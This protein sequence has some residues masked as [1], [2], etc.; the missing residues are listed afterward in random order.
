M[1]RFVEAM[2]V[3]GV[4]AVPVAAQTQ[5]Q[6]SGARAAVGG[7]GALV[8]PEISIIGTREAAA[9]MPGSVSTIDARAMEQSR[10]VTVNEA[11]RSLPGIHVRDEEGFG[12]R[13]NIGLRGLNPTR[14][15]KVTLLED[16][17]P[18][19]YAPYGDNASYYF[20]PVDRFESVELVKGVGT[21][22]YGPQSIGGVINFRTYQ[23]PRSFQGFVQLVGGNRKFGDA[24][25]QLGGADGWLFDATYKRGRG[26]RDN[27]ESELTD[28]NLKKVTELGGGHRLTAKLS[29]FIEDSQVT[30]SGLT[31]KEFELLGPR[32]NPFKNDNFDIGRTGASLTH[33]WA[34]GGGRLLVTQA[35]LSKF[36]RDWWRQSSTTTDT[37]CNPSYAT[38]AADRLAGRLV[39]VDRCNSTQGRLRNYLTYGVESRASIPE[40]FGDIA[41]VFDA[42]LKYHEEE[43]KRKQV[44]ANSP[45]GRTGTLAEDNIRKTRAVS[46]FAAAHV[47][48]AELA[49]VTP[50][51]RFESIRNERI[52]LLANARGR[53][54]LNE[55]IPGIGATWKLTPTSTLFAGVHRGFAPPR[56]EDVINNTGGSTEVKSERSLNTELGWRYESFD[57]YSAQ[58]TFFR[59]DFDR[60]TAVGSI[61]GGSTPLA[62][63]EALFQGVELSARLAPQAGAMKGFY[64]SAAV[65][66]LPTA[67]QVTPFFQVVGG[68][69]I[70][71]SG[72]G[73]RQPYAPKQT[74]TVALGYDEG[75]YQA[76]LEAVYVGKQFSDFAN[77]VAPSADGQRGE[78]AAHTVLNFTAN[79][80]FTRGGL[81]FLAV[82]NL[83]DKV[84]I[85]DRTR[86]IQVGA[87]RMVQLGVRMSF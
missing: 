2:L 51:V 48:F 39:D 10:P 57:G 20:P 13:P 29:H 4:L 80:Q 44:N 55:V 81:L 78:I 8:L 72:G 32:Y 28:L 16:G 69:P 27:I 63:G 12:L 64:S 37:Q 66:Y 5:E 43:Q 24:K 73:K 82:K 61:A 53:D 85:V 35:Y 38:F 41:V 65:T 6:S 21:L 30:Y 14:S 45:T 17:V 46:G 87:P 19:A 74:L 60:L 22:L 42:G 31:Q 34:L 3:A 18:L 79:W 56:T 70:A 47:E 75:P 59:N 25:V 11:L 7:D 83:A 36:D 76:Q 54:T 40:R 62:Q 23:A 52:N 84:Y 50:I 26:A 68:A 86:G 67:K 33:R 77:T 9:R 71:G 58:V 1:A 15:T 49:T